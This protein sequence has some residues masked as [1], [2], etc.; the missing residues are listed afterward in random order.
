MKRWLTVLLGV[1]GLAWP[2][3]ALAHTGGAVY[4]LSNSAHGNAVIVF[5]RHRSQPGRTAPLRGERCEQHD[6]RVPRIR[7]LAP[8]HPGHPVRR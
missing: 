7:H 5:D 3:N 6:L 4:T 1:V 8:P 2:A